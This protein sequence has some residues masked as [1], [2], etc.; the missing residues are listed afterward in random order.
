MVVESHD[1]QFLDNMANENNT[2]CDYY[3][4]IY[5]SD[6]L[7]DS[8][9]TTQ[10]FF[11]LLGVFIIFLCTSLVFVLYDLLVTRRQNRVLHTAAR[12]HQIVGS[13][14]PEAVR[15][16]LLKEQETVESDKKR[17]GF[18][19]SEVSNRA[20]IKNFFSE[21]GQNEDIIPDESK[22]IADLFPH[23]TIMFADINGFTAWSSV[24]EPCQ[25]FTLLETVYHGFDQIA[26]ARRVFKVETVGD[27]YVAVAGLPDPRQDQ[28][29]Y[30]YSLR[31]RQSEFST[32]CLQ[33]YHHHFRT[34]IFVIFFYFVLQRC[35]YGKICSRLCESYE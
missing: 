7:K 9:K 10:P 21:S 5:P 31:E 20:G 28:Y 27:C 2:S 30:L 8:Y 24:R 11:Y 1:A 3:T 6:T 34:L 26:R 4:S 25:V 19:L 29:V 33:L 14:F 12:T 32:I 35:C 17:K 16:Q 22:P 13:L 23:T 15:D 18:T